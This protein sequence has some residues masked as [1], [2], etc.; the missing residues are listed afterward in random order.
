VANPYFLG[1]TPVAE[2]KPFSRDAFDLY[3]VV[4]LDGFTAD[5]VT[6][7]IGPR[8]GAVTDGLVLLDQRAG[9]G[10]VAGNAWLQQA[11]ELLAKAGFEKRVILEMTGAALHGRKDVLG[12]YSWGSNDPAI[13]TRRL[14]FGF[15]PGAIAASYVSTDGRTFKE[16]PAEWT[17]GR[18]T[19]RRT[20]FEGS[21]QSL[22][23]TSSARG[24]T[25]IA[26]HVEEPFL[27]AS[28]RP[29]ILFPAYVSG[30]NLAE[31]F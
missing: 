1:T 16:P 4:R 19:E 29:D 18:W 20:F 8:C 26:A 15:V 10:A 9:N 24:V 31:S 2:A 22:A 13:A 7:L 23:G 14:G 17:I 30:F 28:V 12:Y 25:G 27:D 3:L 21:P 6:G 5:D 11:A